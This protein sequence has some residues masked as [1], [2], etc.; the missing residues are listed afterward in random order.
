MIMCLLHHV[1]IFGIQ[2][3]GIS[4]LQSKT[5]FFYLKPFS[6]RVGQGALTQ[7]PRSR[8][9]V[10]KRRQSMLLPQRLPL[11]RPRQ[12]RLPCA[13]QP[14]MS[15]QRRLRLLPNPQPP[16]WRRQPRRQA[17]LQR[18]QRAFQLGRGPRRRRL[19]HRQRQLQ[20]RLLRTPG[21]PLHSKPPPLRPLQRKPPRSPTYS[22]LL[23]I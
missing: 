15:W 22:T 6:C 2:V 5:Y 19:V 23:L 10:L 8:S 3:Y 9:A 21:L 14:T 20:R 13:P 17:S 12:V 1:L 7:L 4:C 18:V 11:P 16:P